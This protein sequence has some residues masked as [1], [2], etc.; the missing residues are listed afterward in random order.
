[1]TAVP[2]Q[3]NGSNPIDVDPIETKEW[4]DALNGVI[5]KEGVERA[6]Y[7]IDEQISHARVNGVVQP[8]HAETPYINTIPVEKQAKLPGDQEI[9]HRIRSYTR[10][11]A[12]A[13][14]LK[15]NKDTNVGGHISSFQSAATLYDV[16]FNHFW[17]APSDKHGGDLVFVQ[18][19]VAT[20]VY[21]RAYMLGRL[22][23][24]HLLNFRQEVDGKG[25]SSYPHPWLMPDFWQFPTVSM[26]LGPIMAIYQARFMKYLQDR[27]LANTEGRKV[28]AFLGDGETDEPESLG[29]IGMAGRENLDNLCFVINCNLQRLDGPVRGNGKIIQELESEFRGAG[30]NVIKLIWGTHWDALFA[31]DK[32]GILMKRLGEIVDGEYQTMKAKNGAYVRKTVFNT[33]ELEALVADWSDEDVWNLNRGGH[34]PHKVYAAFHAAA[35]HKNQPT[36][37]LAKT[38]KGYGMGGS[39]QGMNIAHQAKKMNIEDIKAFRDQFKIPVPDDKLE[40]LP[41]VK[42]EEGSPELNYM[43][44][45]R[46]ELGGYLPQRR[47]KAESLEVPKLEA[48]APLLEAT[49]EG[50]EIS[51]T[52]AFVRLLNIVIKDKTIGKRVVPIVPDESRTFGM[53]GMFRQLG[54]WNQLGQL[55]TPQDHDQLMFYK[56]DKHGQILQEGINEAGAMCD[57]IAAATSYSTHGVPMLPFY[58][59]YSMFGFQRIGDLAWAAGDM[60]SR[61]FLL[62]GTAGRTTLN[63]EGLQHEDGH[64]HLWS[65]AIPNCISYDPSFAFELAVIIQDGMRRMMTNQDDVYYYITLMNEN[66]AH[67]AMPKGAEEDILKGMYQLTSVGDAKAKLKVQLL[68]S[69]TIFREV[70]EAAN[71]LRDDWGVASDI[72]GCPSFTELGRDW[73]AVSRENMLNPANK[74]VLSHVEKLLKDKSGPVI[75]A[76]DYVRMFAEQI[77][78]AIQNIGKRYTVLGTDGYGRSD[79]REKLRHFFEVDR[80]WV[81]VAALKTLA[82]EG[83]IEHQKVAEAIKKYGLDP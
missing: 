54:I 9:E 48:F 20:G 38:I 53:E 49:T 75:A 7:L 55:Y 61:G 37:I 79:T 58:I 71:L 35:N 68:G 52:M 47:A 1:M 17:H 69:G 16:G 63:G 51:T 32:K 6:A 28:W 72:W 66:Y 30:W 15:A 56:E 60:R 33:P 14:V 2:E 83:Q 26:G 42:F 77:R 64:S 65:A 45:R 50:R 78:P 57:W 43:R 80:R 4:I 59:F 74:P 3:K 81:A 31:R 25:I 10:W 5:E 34:D 11:N 76:T 22:S 46:M 21:A 70:I 62:G 19:H 36:V 40:E 24:E 39:G 44:E 67:P 23:E 8:F 12:M 13:L 29:A 41:L 73:N 27:G 82:D 18:G